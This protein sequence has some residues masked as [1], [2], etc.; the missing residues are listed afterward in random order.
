MA[1]LGTMAGLGAALASLASCGD[2]QRRDATR[3][4]LVEEP[5]AEPEPAPRPTRAPTVVDA[6]D[7]I[8][9]AATIDAFIIAT[10]ELAARRPAAVDV[11]AFARSM[12]DEHQ[13]ALAGLRAAT[14]RLTPPLTLDAT[15]PIDMR[16]RLDA[17]RDTDD[18]AFAGAYLRAQVSAHETAMV[19]LQSYAVSGNIAALK[20]L[21]RDRIPEINRHLVQARELETR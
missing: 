5:A 6:Q 4:L 1:A 14:G 7:F 2:P 12:I 20:E 11:R 21:A 18:D 9:R 10:S 8:D 19:T 17:L 16:A 13:R 3:N 15:L